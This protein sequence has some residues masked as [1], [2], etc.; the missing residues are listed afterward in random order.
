MSLPVP[1]QRWICE[2]EPTLG[3]GTVLSADH[4]TVTIVFLASGDTRTYSLSSAPIKRVQFKPGEVVDSHEQWTLSIERIEEEAGL[5]TYIGQRDDQAV[6]LHESELSNFMQFLQPLDRLL[7]SQIDSH[8]WFL[9]RQQA[10][11]QQNTLLAAETFGLS[12][13]R[14]SLIP[15]Q[16]YVALDVAKRFAPRVL[17][18]D[19]VGL[20]KTIEAGLILHQQL[21][22]ERV[23]RVLIIVPETLVHQWLVEMLRRFNLHFNIYDE[24][25]CVADEE[26]GNLQ[27]PFENEQLILCSLS[28]LSSNEQRFEQVS[29]VTWD[30]LI[31]DEAHHLEWTP[32][33]ASRQYLLVE[34]LSLGTKGL[35]LI[36]AT[37]EQVGKEGHFARLRLLDPS[38][39][40]DLDQFLLEE[41]QYQPVA[42]FIEALINIEQPAVVE[43]IELPGLQD[44]L[45]LAK[46]FEQLNSVIDDSLKWDEVR[47]KLVQHLLDRHGTGRVLFRNT[48][49]SI[50]GFPGREIHSYPLE[51]PEVYA[52]SFMDVQD[53]GI[54]SAQQ[55]LSVELLYQALRQKGLHWALVDPRLPWLAQKLK[56]LKPL[57]VLVITSNMQTAKDIEQYLRTK[58]GIH[59]AVFHEG[60]TIIERDR[61]AAFFADTETGSQALICSEIGSEGRN[62]QFSHHLIMFDLPYNPDLLEQRIGRLDRIGQTKTINIHIPYLQKTAQE[63][64]FRWYQEGL[65]AFFRPCSAAQTVFRETKNSLF[66]ALHF[67]DEFDEGIEELIASTKAITRQISEQLEHGRDRLLE[68]HSHHPE[69]AEQIAVNIENFN[70]EKELLQFVN[71]V[72]NCYGIDFEELD[73]TRFLIKPSEAMQ[74]S[75]FPGLPDDGMTVTV[76]RQTA[77]TNEDVHFL[78]WEHP[79]VQN[80][81]DLMLTQEMGNTALVAIKGFNFTPGSMLLETIFS[82]EFPGLKSYVRRYIP[83]TVLRVVMEHSGLEVSAKISMDEIDSAAIKIDKLISIKIVKQ[84]SSAIQR[85]LAKSQ[86]IADQHV[87]TEKQ[88]LIENAL[89]K[90]NAEKSRLVALARV[91]PSV[92]Q[93]E[94]EFFDQIE[95]DLR[96]SAH[97]SKIRLDALR[98][99]VTT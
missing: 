20:G 64:I 23:Q 69:R 67:V 37:P 60:M 56:Q 30:L 94:I 18:A 47:E 70:N 51:L 88:K 41:K 54:S 42:E 31:V 81:I 78:S 89:Q 87:A 48:R 53:G 4:R 11:K 84:Q 83:A 25:R 82:L 39:F 90:I 32:Q 46:W 43:L 72:F 10:L 55:L 66:D 77:L 35:I 68:L 38:R 16:L 12:G 9:L 91:N 22:T 44:D 65:E 7:A 98:V 62:F 21:L 95:S 8:K 97:L 5:I 96:Q 75:S 79:L 99:I 6:V 40:R 59:C 3:L 2:S 27:N 73:A 45:E 49:S 86:V 1:G 76:H 71:M 63:T 92:R 33:F 80:A 14:T 74:L 19:E 17:L 34:K 13:T 29:A 50:Q 57:K 61:A 26:S 85:M 93:E 15:H 58:E 24:E 28:F 52:Q 36:T